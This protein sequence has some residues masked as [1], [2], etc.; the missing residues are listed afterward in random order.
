MKIVFTA[1]YA[2]SLEPFSQLGEL[3]VEGWAIGKPKL[4]ASQIIDLAHDAEVIV[5]SYD[6]I[7]AEVI[8][9]CPKLKVI[10]CTRAN[11]VNIDVQ[12]ARA[13][14]ITVLYTPGRNAD[15]A[16]ELT[17]GL[18]LGLMRHIPQSHAALK[19]GA[20]T[21]ESQS[22]QQTQPGL[23]KDV[24][25]DVSPE[26]PYEVFKG[27]ELRNKTLGLIGYG[28]IGRRV[29]R[30]ARAFG[31]NILV[32]DP[33]VAAEDIDEPGLHKTTLDALFRESDIVSLHL[34]SGPHSDGLVNASLLQSMKPGAK[35][36][37]TSRASVVVE[38]D[39]IEALRHG[40]LGGAAL[41]VYHQEPLWSDH[42]FISELDN[43][44]ITPHIAG[45]TR[46]SIQKHTAMIAADLQRF[47]AGEPLLY[48]WR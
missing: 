31:M 9:S 35:L 3:V 7:T 25:W 42:P 29:A 48:A 10:A 38:A 5:T 23:R 33:F 39:L 44:I 1:E 30:I 47:V 19:R 22:E 13:R 43:V 26:S 11:P 4:Q 16:A 46:E 18:M 20:F 34:S 24:V 36:I 14:N 45:A 28:N 21:R 15:A 40:P 8:H 27:G 6:D 37:N 17:L 2:G 12:A 41:D 32:V